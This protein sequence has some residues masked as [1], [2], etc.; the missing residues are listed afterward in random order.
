MNTVLDATF[1]VI[2]VSLILC[3]NCWTYGFRDN[4]LQLFACII[5]IIRFIFFTS[6]L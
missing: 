5:C 6:E 3:T 2:P 1:S 4:R